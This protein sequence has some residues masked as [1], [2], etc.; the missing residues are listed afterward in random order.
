[1]SEIERHR[2]GSGGEGGRVG[3]RGGDGSEGGRE[4]GRNRDV[5]CRYACF[6]A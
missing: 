1:M 6:I 3:E 5:V 2:E 4:G